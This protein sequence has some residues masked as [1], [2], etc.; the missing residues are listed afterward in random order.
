MS[1]SIYYSA[2][3]NLP[4][5]AVESVHLLSIVDVFNES[6]PYKDEGETLSFY[7]APSDEYILEGAIKLPY[8]DEN[9]I[10]ESV[11]YW[12]NAIT[13]LTSVLST[14][15]WDVR[16]DDCPASWVDDHWEM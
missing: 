15:E 9:T 14:A 3:R 6:F 2:I 12:L 8:Q 5:N 16:I 4:I 1:V 7:S 11:I 10:V 13:H